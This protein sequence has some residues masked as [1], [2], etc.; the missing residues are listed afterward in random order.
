VGTIVS[1]L[2]LISVATIS[3]ISPTSGSIY[4]GVLLTINGNGF[5]YSS[6]NIQITV[7]S[8]N[9]PI[10]QTTPGQ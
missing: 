9:C 1:S 4:G 7:G 6:N 8:T 3:S 5:A 10:V 2:I